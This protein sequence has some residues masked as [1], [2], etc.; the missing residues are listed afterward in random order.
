M[1]EVTK[2]ATKKALAAFCEA[3]N[4]DAIKVSTMFHSLYPNEYI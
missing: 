1:A 3:N 2:R 4:I